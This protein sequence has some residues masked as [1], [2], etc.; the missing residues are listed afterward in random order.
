MFRNFGAQ[1][2]PA[3]STSFSCAFTKADAPPGTREAVDNQIKFA[4]KI[5][6]AK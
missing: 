4:R 5:A 2:P 1:A 6:G 3:I